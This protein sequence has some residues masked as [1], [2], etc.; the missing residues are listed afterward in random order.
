MEGEREHRQ[1]AEQGS[2][3]WL[4]ARGSDAQPAADAIEKIFNEGLGDVDADQSTS[5]P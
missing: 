3:L 5:Q 1:A 4:E 2:E